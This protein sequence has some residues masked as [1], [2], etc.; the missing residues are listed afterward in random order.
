MK[1]LIS[2]FAIA[3]LL[4]IIGC[5]KKDS[6]S[7]TVTTSGGEKKKITIAM[8]PKQKGIPYFSSCADGAREA[9]KEL[10]NIELIYDG[11][12]SGKAEES[13]SLIEQ[14]TLR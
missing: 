13:A 7:G 3:L 6:S 10:G 9:A 11:P 1:Q 14:W 5:D 4:C 12:T 2:C 8:L